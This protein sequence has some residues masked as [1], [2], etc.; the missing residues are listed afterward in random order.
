[1]MAVLAFAF[2]AE[3]ALADSTLPPSYYADHPLPDARQ[4]G[5]AR[6]L[7]E[8]LRCLVCQSQSIADSHA[9]MAGDMRALVRERIAAGEKPEDVRRWLIDRYGD[10]VSFRPPVEPSTWPLWGAPVI[11]LLIGG[12]MVWRYFRGRRA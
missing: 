5:D 10:W 6:T 9:E 1:M 7:M 4:E 8:S 3:P 2:A 12:L 11:F